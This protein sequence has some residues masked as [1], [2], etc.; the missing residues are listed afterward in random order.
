[1]MRSASATR[2]L[3]SCA[4]SLVRRNPNAILS[5]T[6]SQ[7]IEASSWNTT[8]TP[9]GTTPRTGWSSNVIVPSLVVASPASSSSR[10]DLPQPDG[11]TMAKNSPRRR[12]RSSGP[13]ACRLPDRAPLP[14]SRPTGKYLVTSRRRA[15]VEPAPAAHLRA[16]SRGSPDGFDVI[17]KE[18]SVDDLA[19]VDIARDGADHALNLDHSLHAFQ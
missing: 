19:V 10:V 11:P 18:L 9:S 6:V 5:K 13:S 16:S 3:R 15:W 7:G 4:V 8:P 14:R 12:S 2:A 1:M 17:G